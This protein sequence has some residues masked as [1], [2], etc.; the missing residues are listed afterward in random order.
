MDVLES[1]NKVLSPLQEFTDALSGERYV[2]VSYL[3]PVL[4]LFNE[5]ILAEGENDTQL[6]K[7]MKTTI[8]TY[9]NE[10]YSDPG[11]DDLLDMASLLDPRFKTTYIRDEKVDE[12]KARAVEEIKSLL[13]EQQADTG[14]T[15]SALQRPVAAAEPEVKKKQGSSTAQSRATL[16]DEETIKVEL[17]SYLQAVEVDSDTDPLEWWKCHQANFPR[18]AK[19]ARKYLYSCHQCPI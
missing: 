1:V 11:T 5:T 14:G 17:R 10:K 7:D 18:V 4:H 12:S 19:L 8:L 2:S 16:S 3:K 13:T 15:S 9:L 6:T